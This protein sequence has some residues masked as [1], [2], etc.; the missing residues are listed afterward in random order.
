MRRE[1]DAIH[2]KNVINGKICDRIAKR[3]RG[4]NAYKNKNE[5]IGVN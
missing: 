2:K 5:N 3:K 4:K 1:S